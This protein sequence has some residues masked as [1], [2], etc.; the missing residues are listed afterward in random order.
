MSRAVFPALEGLFNRAFGPRLNPLY[1]LGALTIWFFWVVLFTGIYLFVFFDTS[2]DGAYQSTQQLTRDQWWAGGLMRSIHRYASDAAVVTMVLHLVRSFVRDRYRAFRWFSWVTGVPLLWLVALLGITGFWLVWDMLGQYVA[3]LSTELLDWLPLFNDPIAR[4]FLTAG[5][6]DD[7]FFTLLGFLHFLGLPLFLVLFLWLHVIRISAPRI[8]PPS[9]LAWG[10]LVGLLAL[11]L[12]WPV[13]SHGPADL[14]RMP[15]ELELD[16]FYLAPYPLLDFWSR[17]AVW[18]LLGGGTLF[19]LILPW[20]PRRAGAEAARVDPDQC[21][22]CERCYADC[23]YAAIDMQPRQEGGDPADR[24][25]VVDPSLCAGCGICEGSCP[26]AMPFRTVDPLPTGIELPDFTAQ[27]LRER[28][29][30]ALEGKVREGIRVLAFTCG[31]GPNPAALE[32]ERTGVI[33][34]R[35]TGQLPP[36][37]IDYALRRGGAEGVFVTGCRSGDCHYR[38]GNRIIEERIERRRETALRPRVDERRVRVFWPEVRDNREAAEALAAF[39][40]D[41]KTTFGDREEEEDSPG[42]R[43]GQ[44][45]RARVG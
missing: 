35:C 26:S 23:P 27:E 43:Q 28:V 13:T 39:R 33:A 17:G 40:E 15:F 38:R 8:H 10:S 44:K 29:D 16:W 20:L 32:D 3:V 31:Y 22:G 36:A 24:I 7:R 19:L 12:I 37:Y 30:H 34:L 5:S 42:D 9:G 6:V 4:N 1:Y 14:S 45:G 2:V 25:A 41:L 18:S 21:D 11:S